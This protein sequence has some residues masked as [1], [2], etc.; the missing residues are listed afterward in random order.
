MQCWQNTIKLAN[1]AGRIY[2]DLYSPCSLCLPADERVSRSSKLA[3]EIHQNVIEAE[4]VIQL[5][6]FIVGESD[7][8]LVR[9]TALADDVIRQSMITLIHR[10]AP[11]QPGPGRA[12]T[13]DCVN[14][15]RV[16]LESHEACIATVIDN[17][18]YLDIY[19]Q[20]TVLFA[21][22]VP[23]FVL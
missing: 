15:A 18:R 1:I 12:F 20:W 4:R 13:E 11:A 7:R 9:F 19:F 8:H 5:W 3:Q 17:P 2:Q 21:S 14:S 10:A 23:F 22:F 16:T 6:S